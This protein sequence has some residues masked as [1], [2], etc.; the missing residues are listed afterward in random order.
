MCRARKRLQVNYV[1]ATYNLPVLDMD[2]AQQFNNFCALERADFNCDGL[3]TL[4]LCLASP[5]WKIQND[6]VLFPYAWVEEGMTL[7]ADDAQSLKDSLYWIDEFAV[8]VQLW[9]LVS[10]GILSALL[11]GMLYQSFLT[12]S[13][14]KGFVAG[15]LD[16]DTTAVYSKIPHG[17]NHGSGVLNESLLSSEEHGQGGAVIRRED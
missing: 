11:V 2:K 13:A 8:K 3:D 5:S 14:G 1:V 17:S 6:A 4:S 9:S 7:S 15:D 10:A 16:E 12:E